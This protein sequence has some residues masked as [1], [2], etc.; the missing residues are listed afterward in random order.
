MENEN[1]ERIWAYLKLQ[2]LS[3]NR[4]LNHNDMIAMDDD[5]EKEEQ[6]LGLDLG[7]KHKFVTPWTSM[8]VVKHKV[9]DD[10]KYQ[11]LSPS[12]HSN[13]S[14]PD[15]L[16][17]SGTTSINNAINPRGKFLPAFDK[18]SRII[19][20]SIHEFMKLEDYDPSKEQNNSTRVSTDSSACELLSEKYNKHEDQNKPANSKIR[21]KLHIGTEVDIY[22]S[23]RQDWVEGII[24]EIKG[25]L[26]CVVYGK[27]MKWLKK[28]SRQ[29]RPKQQQV[30][31]AIEQQH[32]PENIAENDKNQESSEMKIAME[33]KLDQY[34]YDV[35]FTTSILGFELSP[36]TDGKNC[37]VGN[38]LTKTSKKF[39]ERASIVVAVNDVLVHGGS[40][41]MV[42][43]AIRQAARYPPFKMK[44]RPGRK[45]EERGY[46]KVKVVAGVELKQAASYCVVQIGNARLSTRDIQSDE[47]PE[48]QEMLTFKN[49]RPDKGKRAIVTVYNHSDMLKDQKIGRT[50]WDI[51]LEFDKL[52]RDT[53]ELKSGTGKLV[54]AVI[55]NTIIVRKND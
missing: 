37:I 51:P 12:D 1:T 46:L 24:K 23:T 18:D 25:D 34:D 47:N 29:I 36:D 30:F 2:Q 8:I 6:S 41:E 52:Q 43:D 9:E 44:F 20:E 5:E 10:H 53:L 11:P 16:P 26:I 21:L 7:L 49:F 4:L 22:S 32:K 50:S 17:K 3:R 28:N 13:A 45:F 35:E 40:Y 15:T 55:V 54:G 42:L 19:M 48:W 39:V 33:P 14:I 27:Q 31:Q 38:C